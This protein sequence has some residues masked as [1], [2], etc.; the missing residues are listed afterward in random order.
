M[1]HNKHNVFNDNIMKDKKYFD[2]QD[3]YSAFHDIQ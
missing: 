1:F 2:I 3:K